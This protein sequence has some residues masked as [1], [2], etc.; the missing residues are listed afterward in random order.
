MVKHIPFFPTPFP[1][2]TLYSV[3]CR[4]WIKSGC[5]SFRSILEELFMRRINLHT[6][7]PQGIGMF[8]QMIPQETGLTPDYFIQNTTYF[9]YFSPF[10]TEQKSE[11]FLEY[12]TKSTITGRNNN[13]ELGLTGL[14]KQKNRHLRF[15][16][17]CRKEDMEQY[18]ETYW[19]RSHQMHGVL[20]CH[21]HKEALMDSKIHTSL[22]N[23]GFYPASGEASQKGMQY[24]PFADGMAEKLILLAGNT[25]WLL[26]NGAMIGY[27]EKTHAIY[28]SWLKANEFRTYERTRYKRILQAVKEKY[29]DGFLQLI[30]GF[31][32]IHP[33]TWPQNILRSTRGFVH[34]LFHL[35]LIGLLADSAQNFFEFEF[36]NPLPYEQGYLPYGEGPW[37]CRNPICP[38]N[39]KDVILSTDVRYDN[40]RFC[41][42]LKCPNCGFAYRRSAPIPKEFQYN[43]SIYI[44]EYGPLWEA[45]LRDC[46]I[47][48]GLTIWKTCELLHC[49]SSTVQKYAALLGLTEPK[50]ACFTM[51]CNEKFDEETFHAPSI[52][53]Q[54]SRYRK[55]WEQIINDNPGAFRRQLEA[56]NCSCFRWLRKYDLDWFEQHTPRIKYERTDWKSLDD[57]A[58]LQMQKAVSFLRDMEGKPR[59]INKSIIITTT[60]INQILKESTLARLP[61]TAAFLNENIESIIDFRKRKLV[62]AI[63]SLYDSGEAITLRKI[64][65]LAGMSQFCFSELRDFVLEILDKD[66]YRKIDKH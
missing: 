49:G 47:D 53:D 44:V 54:R 20:M 2:E 38:Y 43:G 24:G 23:S 45:K 16:A 29:G 66:C 34:P 26:Q 41:A 8:T 21:Q 63:D 10:I 35:L 50:G 57:E 61:K 48:K 6:Y 36:K 30:G 52:D 5:P 32:N 4:Y 27:I 17:S 33:Y 15:C 65:K 25:H 59:W 11:L 51:P 7:A 28:D 3:F 18:G 14:Q 55:Q 40:S 64:I 39:G 56:V 60:G 37:P 19:R 58:L 1:D 12:M 13:F 46:L 62:W 42:I 31:D 22:T 9:T